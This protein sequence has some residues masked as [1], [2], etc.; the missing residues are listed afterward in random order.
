MLA[1]STPEGVKRQVVE[2]MGYLAPGGGYV[3]G[4][5]HNVQDDVPPR[6]LLAMWEGYRQM[7]TYRDNPLTSPP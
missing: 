7:S 6:N 4:T 2:N 1:Q 5:I 3:F